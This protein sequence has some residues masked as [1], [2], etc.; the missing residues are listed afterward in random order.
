MVEL[1]LEEVGIVAKCNYA[2]KTLQ[3][4]NS[5]KIDKIRSVV[6]KS[7]YNLTKII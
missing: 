7:G 5:N 3:V 4:A 6:K 1:D 2:N